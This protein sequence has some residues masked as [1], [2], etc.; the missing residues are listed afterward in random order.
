MAAYIVFTRTK[1]L[2]K[3]EL[4]TY[5]NLIKDT[6]DGHPMEVLVSYGVFEVLEG[7]PIE[8]IVIARFPDGDSAKK[9]YY[10]DAYQNASK[11]RYNGALYDG[12]L[13]EGH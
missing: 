8:G 4:E 6:I 9:W 13:V 11:H 3:K 10:S 2:D 12:I 1:T 7:R 5:Q